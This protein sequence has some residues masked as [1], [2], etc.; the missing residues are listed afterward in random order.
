MGPPCTVRE[1]RTFP[2]AH[3]TTTRPRLSWIA[4]FSGAS[5]RNSEMRYG[6]VFPL[7]ALLAC[8]GEPRPDVDAHPVTPPLDTG[9]GGAPVATCGEEGALPEGAR[10]DDAERRVVLRCDGDGNA[11]ELAI[12]TL[13]DGVVRLRYGAGW[14]RDGSLVPVDRVRAEEPLRAGRRGG[15][16]VVCTPELEIEVTPSRC[17]LVA[18]DVRTGTVILED[19]A[20]GGF[21]ATREGSSIERGAAD[22][23]RFYGLGLHTAKS[24][25]LRGSAIELWNTDAFDAAAGGFPPDAKHLYESIPFYLGLRGATAYGVFTDD[26]F[27]TRFDLGAADPSRVRV[28]S[29]RPAGLDQY[30]VAG[31][32]M[33]DV[34]RRYTG[35]TG[36]APLPAPWAIGFHQSRWEGPCDGA[37][38]QERPFCSAS[39]IASVT[40]RFRSEKIPLDGV[41]LDIQHMDG[42]RSFT[43]EPTRFA[44]PTAFFSALAANGVHASIIVDPGIKIDPAWSLYR[45]GAAG[46]HFL[47]FEG[48]VWPGPSVFPDFS[49]K[50]T[51]GWWSSLVASAVSAGVSGTWIDMNEPASFTP[52]PDTVRADGDGHATTM[53]EVHNA[54]AWLEAKATFE[55]AKAAKPSERPFVLSRAAFAGQ[56]RYSAVWTGDAPSTWTTLGAT[57]PQLLSLGLSGIA[58][59]GSDVGGYSGR[60]ESTADLFGRWMALGAISPFFRAHAEKDARR[61]EPWAFDDETLAATRAL[62]RM[63]YALMPYLYSAFEET[64]RTGA[65]VLRP[66]V[67]EFQADPETHAIGDQAMLGPSIMV[68]PILVPGA[69][70]RSVYFPKGR[71]FELHS[72]AVIE[73]PTRITVSA[74]NATLPRDAL[75]LYVREGAV[76]ARASASEVANVGDVARAP[77]IIDVHPGPERTTST[78]YEDDGAAGGAW[79][80]TTFT[81]SR[82]AGVKI[83]VKKE[84]S[85]APKHEK[86]TFRIRRVDHAPSAVT[87]DGKKAAFTWDTADRALVVEAPSVPSFVVEATF[88]GALEADGTVEVP[89]RVRLPADTPQGTAIHVASSAAGWTHLP[90]VRS[91]DFAVGTLRAPRGGFAFFKVTRGGWPTVEKGAAC[92]EIADRP[93]FGAAT[94]AIDVDVTA[95]ADRC[96]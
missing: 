6:R 27:R 88:D 24:I 93:A 59:A 22:G 77:L 60:A 96:P 76:V 84:G 52:M 45:E 8:T 47:D 91:G 4:L 13:A 85:F 48:E 31:P 43:F 81:V 50:K 94:R 25:D 92:A 63:R 41:F 64:S 67:F 15:A 90:L 66:L 35:L 29:A 89:M 9:D 56:Q 32:S 23:E 17:T 61:Q 68:A 39:Q 44:D 65:P 3:E 83:E 34:L 87:F 79:S 80:R 16:V 36:R 26:T 72:G 2:S 33:K 40:S 12:T 38:A 42:F 86:T 73:G 5:W 78:L 82:G 28:S 69:K 62:V 18:K 11:K 74:G 57:L 70:S 51:R 10:R 55:G 54:Y 46:G 75:P 14:T 49:A 1:A 21:R 53:A 20:Q 37:S 7:L 58:F 95:W 19:G 30:L 71:W